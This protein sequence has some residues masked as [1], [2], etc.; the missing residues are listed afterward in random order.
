MTEFVKVEA[1]ERTLELAASMLRT[2]SLQLPGRPM[3][4][5]AQIEAL[6]TRALKAAFP[7]PIETGDNVRELRDAASRLAVESERIH[8]IAGDEFD[9]CGAYGMD[10]IRE[11][12]HVGVSVALSGLV[13][14]PPTFTCTERWGEVSKA[15]ARSDMEQFRV[16]TVTYR[17]TVLKEVSD[18]I[19]GVGKYARPSYN[20]P[21]W[22]PP[23]ESIEIGT[24]D[25]SQFAQELR[26]KVHALRS[27]YSASAH[28]SL[29]RFIQDENERRWEIE[30]DLAAERARRDAEEARLTD[31]RRGAL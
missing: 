26:K 2:Y 24:F 11:V 25:T 27:Q 10:I 15:V 28:R 21:D 8:T 12:L 9:F 31:R 1:D 19:Q 29:Y 5:D 7:A 6:V 30:R 4:T 16:V 23:Q 3:P 13:S 22:T 17:P 14:D 18:F 20:H